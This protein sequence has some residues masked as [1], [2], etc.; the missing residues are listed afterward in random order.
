MTRMQHRD[1][2]AI[3]PLWDRPDTE[4]QLVHFLHAHCEDYI[5]LNNYVQYWHFSFDICIRR[6]RSLYLLFKK[7]LTI[8]SDFTSLLLFPPSDDF[9][10]L[11]SKNK[12]QC[13]WHW[14]KKNKKS[15][16]RV[17]LFSP[18]GSK[19]H[20]LGDCPF[21][22]VIVKGP[23]QCFCMRKSMQCQSYCCFGF[24]MLFFWLSMMPLVFYSYFLGIKVKIIESI[25]I[26]TWCSLYF[27][28]K[29]LITRSV[30]WLLWGF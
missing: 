15:N 16:T 5:Y 17:T 6:C 12:F 7:I 19:K 8:T 4:P 28:T 18:A 27:I 23:F 2:E 13:T 1:I 26:K 29:R 30:P 9:T 11:P 14:T 25:I 24:W 3:D 10:Y 22:T 21:F 20:I